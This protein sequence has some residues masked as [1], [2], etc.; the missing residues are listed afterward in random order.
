MNIKEKLAFLKINSGY[1]YT[2]N[3]IYEYLKFCGSPEEMLSKKAIDISYETGIE[4]SKAEKFIKTISAFDA[5][6]ELSLIEKN[7]I[8]LLIYGSETYPESLLDI[9][10]PPLVLYVKGK[11][12]EKFSV[13]VVGTRRTTE[14]GEKAAGDICLKLSRA[15]L[16]I[17]S[18]LARGIDTIAHRAALKANSTTFAV[19]GSGILDIYPKENKKLS[20]EIIAKGGC[21]ISEYP[22]YCPPYKF[23][24]PRRNRI[25]SALSWGVLVIEGDFNSGALITARCALDQG[26]E[27]MALPGPIYSRM[28]N[29]PN[30]LIK[31]GAITITCAKDVIMAIPPSALGEIDLKNIEKDVDNSKILKSLT[32]DSLNI[33]NLLK[34]KGELSVDEISN[35]LS[36]DIPV[37]L[38][39]IF[40]LESNQ[41]I[42]QVAGKYKLIR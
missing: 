38:N 6:K 34:E 21:I 27:V 39:L 20:E 40:E 8:E 9:K 42:V 41:L 28:S 37:L 15:G 3:W 16:N 14:Y 26:R 31:D 22:L 29:G 30:Q 12:K 35:Y 7:G 32:K 36:I 18:G 5:E 17:V 2:E 19:I 4:L 10:T 1:L 33:V 13:A 11:L 25:I 24:F 23:N